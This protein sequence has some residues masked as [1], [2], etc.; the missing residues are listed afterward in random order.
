MSAYSRH[1]SMR[2]KRLNEKVCVTREQYETV[3]SEMPQEMVKSILN[4]VGEPPSARHY[5]KEGNLAIAYF[6]PKGN[7]YYI[8]P[9]RIAR[10]E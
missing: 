2:L 3:V 4:S 10:M 8:W 1:K 5:S 9:N 7:E 6:S